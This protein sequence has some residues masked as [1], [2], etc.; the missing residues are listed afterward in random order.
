VS[1]EHVGNAGSGIDGGADEETRLA[2]V[3]FVG[4]IL[5][6]LRSLGVSGS[7]V[8]TITGEV[9]AGKQFLIGNI[10]AVGKCVLGIQ[11]GRRSEVSEFMRKNRGEARLIGQDIDK[12]PAEDDG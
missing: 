9:H 6:E 3:V 2:E 11:S 10:R 12:T 1:A 7:F 8:L 4:R 5:E